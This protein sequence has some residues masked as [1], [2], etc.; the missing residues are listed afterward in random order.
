MLEGREESVIRLITGCYSLSIEDLMLLWSVIWCL[1][2]Y[3]RL[4]DG[5]LGVNN[6]Y[7]FSLL[8]THQH[9]IFTL[10]LRPA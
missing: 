2:G 5:M 1:V 8:L 9:P 3:V 10:A 6:I 7:S 4:E